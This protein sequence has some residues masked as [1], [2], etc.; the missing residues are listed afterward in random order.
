MKVKY[1]IK[2]SKTELLELRL[3]NSMGTQTEVV[4]KTSYNELKK[5]RLLARITAQL[6]TNDH[7]NYCSDNDCEYVKK[8][9]KV[10][11]KVPDKYEDAKIG[12]IN[13]KN[14]YAWTKHLPVP[15]IQVTGYGSCKF[16]YV[17]G[18]VGQ[19]QYR[20]K[21]KKV[22]IIENK[23]YVGEEA[24]V[25]KNGYVILGEHIVPYEYCWTD[26]HGYA[27]TLEEARIIAEDAIIVGRTKTYFDRKWEEGCRKFYE[28]SYCRAR[29][30]DLDTMDMVDDEYCRDGNGKMKKEK[31]EIEEKSEAV[32]LFLKT[33]ERK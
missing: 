25:N 6:E 26:A 9:V 20:Y 30:I 3:K 12:T 21:I 7:D 14:E 22:E 31:N 13:K 28:G 15:E 8:V 5:C 4:P 2:M 11:T 27:K 18:G 1:N 24:K 33:L 29:I 19:H 10:S 32:K 16:K 17:E 23:K